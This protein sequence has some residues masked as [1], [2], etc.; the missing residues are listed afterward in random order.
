MS[1]MAVEPSSTNDRAVMQMNVSLW[2]TDQIWVQ[3]SRAVH[4]DE[5]ETE[6]LAIYERVY[7]AV[8]KAHQEG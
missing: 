4:S 6:L 1:R 3:M 7:K 5:A 8:N 2:I